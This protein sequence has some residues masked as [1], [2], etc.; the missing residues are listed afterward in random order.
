MA[1]MFQATNRIKKAFALINELD[2]T[3]FSR[4]LTRILQKLHLRDE[5]S[6]SEDEEEKLQTA[7]GLESEDV[8]LILETIAFII[9]QTAYHCAK[10]TVLEQQLKNLELD[11]DKVSVFVK[12]W[13][14]NGKDVIDQL[15]QRTIAINQLEDVSWR[16]NL[17]MGQAKSSKM[18]IPNAMLELDVSNDNGGEDKLR[19]E[20][21]HKEL[22]EFYT[23]LETIQSQLDSI[24]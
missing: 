13:A 16:L 2:A 21:S 23:K 17:Q 24:S 8:Q 22:Y 10:P 6:F 4:I 12:A 19:M 20:F 15:R 11:D 7:L 9:E 18:K 3:K 5:R 1:L 14:T